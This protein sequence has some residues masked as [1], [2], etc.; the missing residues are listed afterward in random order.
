M[1]KK[2]SRNELD[3][4]FFFKKSYILVILLFLLYSFYLLRETLKRGGNMT[5]YVL[6]LSD[7]HVLLYVLTPVFLIGLTAFFSIGPIQNY[8]VFRFES[9]RKWY[10]RNISLIAKFVSVYCFVLIAI[11][12]VEAFPALSLNNEW[13]NFAI[14][15][16]QYHNEFLITFPPYLIVGATVLL[17]WFYL[18][19]YG[20]LYYSLYIMTGKTFVP[21]LIV[22][23]V[24]GLNIVA[25]LSQ[26]GEIS[27]YLFYNKVNIFQYIYLFQA[28]QTSFPFRA[29]F[30][31][32]GVIILIY[33]IGMF[34]IYKRDLDI[35]KGKD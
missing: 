10:Q 31:W 20:M 33:L 29:F 12:I 22:F 19:F 16:Y 27:A 35:P 14:H 21:F 5:D 30:Y 23:L 7:F 26:W 28:S 11:M 8:V 25:G 1:R 18:F 2:T 4:A 3:S 24:N 17:L 32:F 9:K 34:V 15:Y 13:S 6:L